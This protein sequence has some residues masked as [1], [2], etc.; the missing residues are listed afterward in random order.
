MDYRITLT[1]R[2]KADNMTEA[3]SMAM[4]IKDDASINAASVSV[5]SL[6]DEVK[7][8]EYTQYDGK[9]ITVSGTPKRNKQV[10]VPTEAWQKSMERKLDT[11]YKATDMQ[12]GT[13]NSITTGTEELKFAL[14]GLVD[15]LGLAKAQLGAERIKYFKK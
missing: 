7:L 4:Q 15:H 1:F 11:V 13:I 14:D 9:T 2:V 3:Q 12:N 6:E 8:G 10:D 5:K